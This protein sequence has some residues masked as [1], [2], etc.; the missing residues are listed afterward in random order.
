MSI[1]PYLAAIDRDSVSRGRLI[2]HYDMLEGSGTV[3]HDDVG[4]YDAVLDGVSWSTDLPTILFTAT[5]SLSFD[6]VND[7]GVIPQTTVIWDSTEERSISFW[8]KS[9]SI[10]AAADPDEFPV[11]CMLKSNRTDPF[12]IWLN[13]S[14]SDAA[15]NGLNFG[16]YSDFKKVADTYATFSNAWVHVTITYDGTGE[17]DVNNYVVYINGVSYGVVV[18]ASGTWPVDS[19]ITQ[20]GKGNASSTFF[21][22]KIF[23]LRIYDKV[24]TP[25]E[26]TA[27]AS[28]YDSAWVGSAGDGTWEDEDSW[29]LSGVPT[30]TSAVIF[31]G[32]DTNGTVDST[33]L[34]TLESLYIG[35]GFSGTLDMA[36]CYL[37]VNGDFNHLSP[38]ILVYPQVLKVSGDCVLTGADN[39]DNFGFTTIELFGATNSDLS[40]PIGLEIHSLI[41]NADSGITKTLI[42]SETEL[43]VKSLK[44]DG[45]IL[46]FN[47]KYITVEK[48]FS[49]VGGS[50]DNLSDY[51]VNTVGGNAFWYGQNKLNKLDLSFGTVVTVNVTGAFLIRNAIVGNLN[52]TGSAAQCL[53]CEEA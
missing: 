16:F 33:K 7:Y 35:S 19:N 42:G 1:V 10:G 12:I 43:A 46:D 8:V 34:I 28:G 2:N 32:D 50:F 47:T 41:V 52:A 44:V 5:H 6:G 37:I 27:L 26:V 4:L 51:V 39:I 31:N 40:L 11:I 21:N 3:L 14:H 25:A 30:S 49:V 29:P 23:D 24:L 20:I 17:T 36:Y 18:G 15:L 38:G 22:G 13:D 45:G 9:D 53:N 48:D